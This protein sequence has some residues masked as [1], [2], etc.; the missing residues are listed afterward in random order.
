MFPTAAAAFYIPARRHEAS[1]TNP[2]QHMLFGGFL[3]L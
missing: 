2:D 1:S 3:L